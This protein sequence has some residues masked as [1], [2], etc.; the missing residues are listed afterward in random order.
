MKIE[1]FIDF[2]FFLKDEEKQIKELARSFVEKEFL[3]IISEYHR[4]GKFPVQ[5]VSKLAELGFLGAPF[6]EYNLAGLSPTEYGLLMLELER[7]DSGLRS[8]VSVQNSLVMYPILKWGSKEQK[9]FYI[10]KLAKGEIIGFYGLTEPDFGSNPA[11]MRTKLTKRNGKYY[12]NGSKLWITNG[13]IGNLGVIWAKDEEENIKGV[14]VEKGMA[15]FEAR[16]IKGKFSLRASDTAELF[17]EDVLIDEDHILPETNSLKHP[18]SCLNEARFGI[19]WGSIGSALATSEY[20]LNYSKE[21][22]QFKN[23][24]IGT[25]QII[26]EKLVYMVTEISKAFSLMLH[27]SKLKEKGLLKHYQ[28]SLAKRNNV[29]IARECARLSREILGAQGIVDEHPVIR[30]M[31]NLES[32]YTYEGTNDI[33]TLVVGEYLTGFRAYNPPED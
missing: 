21:R 32:V 3:P 4:E 26:Q 2:E 30:H 22:K 23:K 33:H 24:P 29:N 13:T 25:H 16:E 8:F 15:G 19:A 1:S 28:V 27:L 6:S 17:F 11:G 7:G 20:A 9:D 12:L 18:L 31:L 14:I 5:I 10:P